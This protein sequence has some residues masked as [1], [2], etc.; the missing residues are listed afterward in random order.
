L[1][2]EEGGTLGFEG[3]KLR[4][5]M[6]QGSATTLFLHQN[7]GRG[8]IKLKQKIHVRSIWSY[9]LLAPNTSFMNRELQL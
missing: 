8:F 6:L 9:S 7:F 5:Q 2:V 4:S 3:L 1:T